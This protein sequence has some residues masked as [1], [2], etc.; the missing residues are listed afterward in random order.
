MIIYRFLYLLILQGR[1]LNC[2]YKAGF[3]IGDILEV[4]IKDGK[5]I[6]TKKEGPTFKEM[7]Q[8]FYRNGGKYN[9]SII[10]DDQPTGKEVW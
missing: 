2:V 9:E 4:D 3:D 6:F 8:D 1:E 5:L 10:F 7:I